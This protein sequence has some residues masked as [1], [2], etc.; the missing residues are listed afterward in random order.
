MEASDSDKD[1]KIS[2]PEFLKA[3]RAQTYDT[4]IASFPLTKEKSTLSIDDK[5][6]V[7]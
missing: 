5:D 2:Y 6:L 4:A 1:G 3:F 7:A